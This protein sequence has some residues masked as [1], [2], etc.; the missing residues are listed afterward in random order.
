MKKWIYGIGCAVVLTTSAGAVFAYKTWSDQK[1]A[2]RLAQCQQLEPHLGKNLHLIEPLAQE[3]SE[4]GPPEERERWAK[5]WRESDTKRA[6]STPNPQLY[7]EVRELMTKHTGEISWSSELMAE[8][9]GTPLGFR[10]C[11]QGS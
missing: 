7:M 6:A 11:L 3:I 5:Y 4:G 10:L 1:A 8:R 9:T 2:L